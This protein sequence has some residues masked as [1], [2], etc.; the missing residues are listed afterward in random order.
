[1]SVQRNQALLAVLIVTALAG[2]LISPAVP[3]SPSVGPTHGFD[4]L[5]LALLAILLRLTAPQQ[6]RWQAAE[7]EVRGDGSSYPALVCP[8]RR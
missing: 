7:H 3:S 6:G 5:G 1:M 2:I 4:L 8:L